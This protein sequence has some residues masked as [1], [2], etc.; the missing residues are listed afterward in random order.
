[1]P[2]FLLRR[3]WDGKLEKAD[4]VSE[5][6]LRGWGEG[7]VRLCEVRKVRNPQHHRK[8]F[9]VLLFALENQETYKTVE[10]LLLAVKL[11][12]GHFDSISIGAS[13]KVFYVPKS[14][15]F[16]AMGQDEFSDFY[17]RMLDAL[18]EITG[19][20]QQTLEEGGRSGSGI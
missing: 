4:K 8:A 19:I 5:D 10:S 16:S 11:Q 7:E 14:I 2:K 12:T 18:Y 3:T 17:V 1:M 20:P 15:S 6:Y 13:G 9:A